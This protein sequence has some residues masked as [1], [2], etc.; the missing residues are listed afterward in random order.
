VVTA[1]AKGMLDTDPVI[2]VLAPTCFHCSAS[3]AVVAAVKDMLGMA[4]VIDVLAPTCFHYSA[5]HAA[6]GGT[7]S[8]LESWQS[9]DLPA[10]YHSSGADAVVAVGH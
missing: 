8:V 2:D 10:C 4:L 5:S 9:M 7:D 3:H 1:A 6:E